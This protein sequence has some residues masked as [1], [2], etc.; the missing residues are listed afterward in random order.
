MSDTFT[1]YQLTLTEAGF[2]EETIPD[3]WYP[4]FDGSIELPNGSYLYTYGLDK[5]LIVDGKSPQYYSLNPDFEVGK[6]AI[7]AKAIE[8]RDKAQATIDQIEKLLN[9]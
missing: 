2:K 6:R 1:V 3:C 7:L 9:P 4:E 8:N 5:A